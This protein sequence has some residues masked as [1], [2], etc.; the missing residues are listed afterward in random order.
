MTSATRNIPIGIA[1]GVLAGLFLGDKAEWFNVVVS[2]YVGLLQMVVLPYV[3]VSLIA[4]IGRLESAQAR[5]LFIRVGALSLVLWALVLGVV[6]LLPFTFPTV[7]SASFFSNTLVEMRPPVDLIALYIPANPFHSLANNIVPAVVVFGIFLGVALIGVEGKESLLENLAVIERALKQANG[8]VVGLAPVGLFAIATLTV[9][10]LDTAEFVKLRVYVIGYVAVALLLALWVLPGL[11][12]CLTPIP[13]RRIL[14]KSLDVLLTSFMLNDIFVVL[15]MLID[16]AKGLLSAHGL[17]EDA[18]GS[19]P[20]VIVTAF[21]SFPHAFK[22]LTLVFVLFAAW[23]SDTVLVAADYPRLILAGLVSLFGSVIVA[24]PFMLDLV[25]VPAD[26]F[27]LYLATGPVVERVGSLVSAMYMIT[28]ALCGSYALTGALRLSPARI[29]RYVLVTAVLTLVTLT[30]TGELL[31][32]MGAGTYDKNDL[33]AEMK[34]LQPPTVRVS[35]L[36]EL[37]SRPSARPRAGLS[38]LD[39]IRTRGHLRVGYVDGSLPY[40]YFNT[41]GELVGFDVEMAHALAEGL[42]VNVEFVPLQRHRLAQALDEGFCDIVMAGVAVTTERAR[43]MLFSPPYIDET[44][45]FVVPDHRRAEFSSAEWVRSTA[46][47]RVAVPDLPYIK[48]II[49][50]EFPGVEIVPVPVDRVADYFAGRGERVDAL[51]YTAERGSYF[52]LMYPAFSVAVP[53]PLKIQ[54]PLAYAV[55][56]HDLELARFLGPWIDLQRKNGMIAAL[57]NHWILGRNARPK[58]PHWS[59]IRDVLHWV[60]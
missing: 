28:L 55:A 37:P 39:A 49:R 5:L 23:Y 8:L 45:S 56:R 53:H 54:I 36:R 4:G 25:K 22:L 6:M 57:Y 30:A 59:V 18:R 11:A 44:L 19:P 21:F 38:T 33:V 51:V 26:I 40:T 34:L 12:A 7:E 46:G 32:L 20:E 15:P 14:S 58:Q 41:R 29:L 48:Q 16:R 13:A 3:L 2:A 42:G 31:R 43:E 52:T 24:I 35:V 60:N 17:P 47:L 10:T 1:L 9:G 50:R 27:Q